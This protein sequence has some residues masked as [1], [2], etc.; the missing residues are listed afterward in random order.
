M[1]IVFLVPDYLITLIKGK[2]GERGSKGRPDQRSERRENQ[3]TAQQERPVRERNIGICLK[4]TSV[5]IRVIAENET[6]EL[7]DQHT[8]AKEKGSLNVNFR[9]QNSHF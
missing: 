1:E 6:V 5:F 8:R 2:T 4:C 9:D 3:G 7:F